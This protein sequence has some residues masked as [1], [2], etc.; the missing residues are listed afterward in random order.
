MQPHAGDLFSTFSV[1]QILLKMN[2]WFFCS[3]T[4]AN[5]IFAGCALGTGGA[6]GAST[7]SAQDIKW[8]MEGVILTDLRSIWFDLYGVFSS[9][10]SKHSKWV[11]ARASKGGAQKIPALLREG[12]TDSP[13]KIFYFYSFQ[14]ENHSRSIKL[15]AVTFETIKNRITVGFPMISTDFSNSH[16]VPFQEKVNAAQGTWID[17]QYLFDAAKLLAKCRS[18]PLF[19][20]LIFIYSMINASFNVGYYFHFMFQLNSPQVHPAVHIS[21]RILHR[22]LP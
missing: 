14:W 12:E 19:L 8:D 4:T 6:T 9:G 10:E 7:T 3:V 21:L 11:G 1:S 18:S 22:T 13:V 16:A 15:E 5:M 2:S 20:S 17:W